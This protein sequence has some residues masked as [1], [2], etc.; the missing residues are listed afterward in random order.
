[1]TAGRWTPSSR[2]GRPTRTTAVV[3]DWE[4]VSAQLA[5]KQSTPYSPTS[6]HDFMHL[7][8]L[9]ADGEVTTGSYNFSA[10]AERNAENQ[11]HLTDPGTVLAYTDYINTVIN[12]YT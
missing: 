10:N 1:M 7:K 4:K 2:N 9:I 8:V 6:V 11:I 3:A 12:A 5:H